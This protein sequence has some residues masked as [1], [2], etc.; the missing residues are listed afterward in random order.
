M[1]SSASARLANLADRVAA[2]GGTLLVQSEPDAG[3][4]IVAPIEL[5]AADG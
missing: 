2:H 1:R 3:T 4:L 5:T